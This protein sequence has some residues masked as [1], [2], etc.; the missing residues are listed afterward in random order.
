MRHEQQPVRGKLVARA[1]VVDRGHN[2]LAGAGC[3]DEQIAV[4]SAAACEFHLLEEPLL[5]R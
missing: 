2:G 5:E 3:R 4:M 1:R